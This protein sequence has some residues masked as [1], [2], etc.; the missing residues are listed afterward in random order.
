MYGNLIPFVKANP[1]RGVKVLWE[2]AMH[3]NPASQSEALWQLS[4]LLAHSQGSESAFSNTSIMQASSPGINTDDIATVN[5][6]PSLAEQAGLKGGQ[7]KAF[8]LLQLAAD[9]GHV[10]AKEAIAKLNE[11][12]AANG[13]QTVKGCSSGNCGC[14]SNTTSSI[15]SNPSCGNCGCSNM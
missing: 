3:G 4:C 14:K 1:K 7:D 9:L 2:L 12:N 10:H 5:C 11:R 15:N 6:K 8:E 13:T